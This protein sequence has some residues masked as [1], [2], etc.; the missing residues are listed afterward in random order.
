MDRW[1]VQ[2]RESGYRADVIT[3][4]ARDRSWLA[5]LFLPLARQAESYRPLS[6][7]SHREV[8]DLRDKS[9]FPG[10]K[11][12]FVENVQ[13]SPKN[14]SLDHVILRSNILQLL[15]PSFVLTKKKKNQKLHCTK[16]DS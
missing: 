6:I 7:R 12:F 10:V 5:D 3:A 4:A 14:P 2:S 9:V 16:I 1:T 13:V 15:K 11:V 8:R